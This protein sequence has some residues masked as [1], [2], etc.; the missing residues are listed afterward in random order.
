MRLCELRKST[1]S[2]VFGVK[3][4]DFISMP[5]FPTSMDVEGKWWKNSTMRCFCPTKWIFSSKHIW[6]TPP[7]RIWIFCQFSLNARDCLKDF[8][9][10][11]CEIGRKALP[12][13]IKKIHLKIYLCTFMIFFLLKF[14]WKLWGIFRWVLYQIFFQKIHIVY[15]RNENMQIHL[16][17]LPL[18]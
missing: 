18:T 11:D 4:R 5:I 13:S 16:W 2:W 7:L 8:F 15:T 1:F 6:D 14:K 17:K 3:L 12:K 10:S 9:V